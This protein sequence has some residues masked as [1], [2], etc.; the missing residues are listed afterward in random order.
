MKEI[1]QV[2]KITTLFV[3][4]YVAFKYGNNQTLA[5]GHNVAIA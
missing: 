4:S 1:A 2:V 5:H 3:H